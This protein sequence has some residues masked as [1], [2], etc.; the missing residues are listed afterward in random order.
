M[1]C[2]LNSGIVRFLEICFKHIL[3]KGL[4]IKKGNFLK[5]PIGRKRLEVLRLTQEDCV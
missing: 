4:I 5:T 2:Y 1:L 3:N